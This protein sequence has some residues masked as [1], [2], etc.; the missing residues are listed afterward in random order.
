MEDH[1]IAMMA[2]A[3]EGLV[4]TERNLEEVLSDPALLQRVHY[5]LAALI[6]KI[7]LAP[8]VASATRLGMEL[9]GDLVRPP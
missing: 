4:A 1:G 9:Q 8:D 3:A 5:L 6:E 2:D 7:V